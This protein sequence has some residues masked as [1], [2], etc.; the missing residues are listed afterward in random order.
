MSA[1]THGYQ[2]WQGTSTSIWQRRWTITRTGLRLCWR[3]KLLKGI[4]AVVWVSALGLIAF[5]FLVGQMLSSESALVAFVTQNF[6]RKAKAITDG[7]AAW[8]LLYPDVTIDGLFRFTL[9]YISILYST[10]CYFAVALFVPK[11]ISHDLS[12]RAILIYNSK[13]LTRFDYLLGKFGIVFVILSLLVVAPLT[14]IW[15]LSNLLSPDWSFFWHGF[16][17]LVR[18]LAA[19]SITVM[20]LS[21]LAL[22]VSALVKKTSTATALW[23]VLW[24]VSGFIASAAEQVFPWGHY[25]SPANCLREI[26][27]QLFDVG[28]VVDTAKQSLPFFD[29]FLKTLPRKSSIVAET[30][31]GDAWVPY[32]FLLGFCLLSLF[33]ISKRVQSE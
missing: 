11:L 2:H 4:F 21:L 26:T 16:P 10:L 6:G 1:L 15:F 18:A 9:L 17:A 12:S 19:G 31:Q 3:S 23:I 22:A 14:V 20:A 28:G 30:V 29:S 33:A 7:L 13:A 27:A 8:I 24:L 5:H 25:L 32:G